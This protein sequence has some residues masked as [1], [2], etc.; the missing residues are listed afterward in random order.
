M[1]EREYH[2]KKKASMSSTDIYK[3][4]VDAFFKDCCLRASEALNYVEENRDNIH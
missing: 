3:Y 2:M 1:T 4:D